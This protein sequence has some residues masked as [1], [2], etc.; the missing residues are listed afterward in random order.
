M[1]KI[2]RG[3]GKCMT[4]MCVGKNIGCPT[5]RLAGLK[6]GDSV[7]IGGVAYWVREVRAVGDGSESRAT[8]A[9]L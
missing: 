6:S 8:L 2:E 4:W 7:E 5:S 3:F 1:V 9:R